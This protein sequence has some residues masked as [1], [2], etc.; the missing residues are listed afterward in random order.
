MPSPKVNHSVPVGVYLVKF[1]FLRRGIHIL[2]GSDAGCGDIKP[3]S[4]IVK[5]AS[6]IVVQNRPTTHHSRCSK[7]EA[8]LDNVVCGLVGGVALAIRRG[9]ETSFA[10]GRMKTFNANLQMI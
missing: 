6:S 8:R 4:S 3:A 9:S 10:H 1:F 5:P 2:S 7:Y